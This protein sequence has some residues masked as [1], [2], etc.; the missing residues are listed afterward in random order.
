MSD[1]RWPLVQAVGLGNPRLGRA[2]GVRDDQGAKVTPRLPPG[3]TGIIP[4]TVEQGMLG[5]KQKQV[6][7]FEIE[8]SRESNLRIG[9][10]YV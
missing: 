1:K 4:R 9:H 10:N 8:L 7:C 5:K 2:F 3:A 6:F